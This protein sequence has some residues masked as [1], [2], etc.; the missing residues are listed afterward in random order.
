MFDFRVKIFD[1]DC[2]S[3]TSDPDSFESL[4]LKDKKKREWTDGKEI[5]SSIDAN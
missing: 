4:P 1:S 3:K 2:H 5:K